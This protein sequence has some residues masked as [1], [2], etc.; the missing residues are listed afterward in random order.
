MRFV[1]AALLVLPTFVQA[2]DIP[3]T[4]TDQDQQTVVAAL[5]AY[6][7]AGGINVATAAVVILQKLQQ[8]AQAAD[9]P[10]SGGDKP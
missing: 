3:I 2:K 7:K 10:K 1:F 5:D 8:A 6:V 9:P 4:L